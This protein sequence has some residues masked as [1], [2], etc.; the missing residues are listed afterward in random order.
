MKSRSIQREKNPVR[1]HWVLHTESK[2]G[3]RRRPPAFNGRLG[4]GGK[5][6]LCLSLF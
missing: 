4:G 1:K 6:L 5:E 3:L 2:I